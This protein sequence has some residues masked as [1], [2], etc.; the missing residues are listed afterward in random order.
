MRVIGLLLRIVS[1]V[2]IINLLAMIFHILNNNTHNL[3]A[4]YRCMHIY[5]GQVET[6]DSILELKVHLQP[7]LTCSE[8]LVS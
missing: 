5:A 3:N 1:V 4:N 8:F 6:S 7:T 2:L